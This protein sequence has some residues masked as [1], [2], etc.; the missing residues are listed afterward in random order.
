MP[1][2]ELSIPFLVDLHDESKAQSLLSKFGFADWKTAW[3]V[4][5]R[6]ESRNPQGLSAIYSFLLAAL[7]STPNPDRSLINFERFLDCYGLALFSELDKNPRNIE[8]LVTIFSSS[9][10]LT[11]I[12]LRTPDALEL[13]SDRY[14]LSE[15]KTI[16]Q[17]QSEAN[18]AMQ[19]VSS[20]DDKLDAF[21]R[22]Q[23]RE[24]LRIGTNDFL[25]LYDLRSVFSQLSRM[26]IGIVRSCLHLAI[27]QTGISAGGLVV[28]AMGKLGGWELN[29]S[30]D[31]DLLF[32][33]KNRADDYLK[34]A[35]QV[36][37]NIS[38]TT[39]EGFLYRVDLRLRPWGNDGPLITSLDGYLQYFQKDARL[40]E[41]QA[42]LKSRPI[43]GNISFGEELRKAIEPF[44]FLDPAEKVRAGIFAM[45]QRTEEFLKEKG[46]RWG[47][48]KL[49]EGSIRDIEFVVQFLQMTHPSVRTRSTLK[50]IQR[51]REEDFLPPMD[52]HI[53]IDGYSFLRTIEHYLQMIDYRQTYTLPADPTALELLARR[54]GFEGPQAGGQFVERYEQHCRAVRSIFLKYVGNESVYNTPSFSNASPLVLQH[55]A[56]IGCFLQF[57]FQPG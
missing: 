14:A 4:L 35:E 17:F 56:H 8:F 29:Y 57:N 38:S 44:L 33:S 13:L 40:W 27:Q 19:S 55:I 7:G 15:R 52:A 42:F 41:K 37:K 22:Y 18:S 51:L 3:T 49:G 32:V 36:I 53:L 47:E 43:A 30:S 9:P 34:L 54:L 26:A 46:R 23:R 28:M 20:D 39:P 1:Y 21:R 25:G 45:K 5:R 31:I 12:L 48:I 16:E 6:M 50:A 10:F 2:N 24:F 11:E